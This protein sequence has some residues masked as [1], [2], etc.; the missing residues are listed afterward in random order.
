MCVLIFSCFIFS[1]AFPQT[2][3]QEQA[4]EDIEI[5]KV[6]NL[7]DFTQE[8][9]QK[10]APILKNG[11]QMREK[12]LNE[13]RDALMQ[14]KKYGDLSDTYLTKL[15]RTNS[16]I[17]TQIEEILAPEQKEKAQMIFDLVTDS[18][19]G[20]ITGTAPAIIKMITSRLSLLKD[21]G[22]VSVSDE[23]AGQMMGPLAQMLLEAFGRM[24]NKVREKILSKLTSPKGIA[25][26]E[27][28]AKMPK[29]K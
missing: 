12:N 1:P 15:S 20:T 23:M 17:V 26:V 9:Y 7:F 28:K 24:Q 6:L 16:K 27:Q 11:R 25:I 22:V 5:L 4:S 10:L 29:K 18:E 2:V 21:L 3:N 13:I 14:G 8:Q 19:M